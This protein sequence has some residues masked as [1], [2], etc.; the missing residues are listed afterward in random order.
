[1]KTWVT[2]G[3]FPHTIQ[4]NFLKDGLKQEARVFLPQSLDT[5]I[6]QAKNTNRKSIVLRGIRLASY[7]M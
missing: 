3:Y 5:T 2:E 6:T 7:R 1:M 4:P